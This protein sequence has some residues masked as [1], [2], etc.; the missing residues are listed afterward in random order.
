[1]N[2]PVEFHMRLSF[3]WQSLALYALTL[4]I[5]VITKALWDSTLQQGIVNVVISDPIVVL[6][7]AFVIVSAVSLLINSL[8]RRSIIIGEDSL[9]YVSRFHERTFHISEIDKLSVAKNRRINV[10]GVLAVV[11]IHIRGRRRPLRIRPGLFDHE[12]QLISALLHLRNH[13]AHH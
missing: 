6:L 1:M 10:R 4:I 9:T 2:F 5:Y 3:Y 7:G 8:S 11:K 13:V 12:H